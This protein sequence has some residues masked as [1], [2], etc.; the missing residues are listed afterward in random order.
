ML[1]VPS[2]WLPGRPFSMSKSF[3]INALKKSRRGKLR[4]GRATLRAEKARCTGHYLLLKD[5]T[6]RTRMGWLALA[7]M[8]EVGNRRFG[9]PSIYNYQHRWEWDAI[10]Q[11]AGLKRTENIHPLACHARLLGRL[12]NS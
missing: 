6:W 7:A 4:L 2:T 1:G 9:V 3:K 11:K 8:D 5:H 10:L 12:T